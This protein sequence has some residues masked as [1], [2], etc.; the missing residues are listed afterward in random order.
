M[1]DGFSLPKPSKA[2]WLLNGRV[3]LN[4]SESKAHTF[5]LEVAS[6]PSPTSGNG[7]SKAG[8]VQ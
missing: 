3:A 6:I 4:H 2:D 7:L 5:A 8:H 1:V